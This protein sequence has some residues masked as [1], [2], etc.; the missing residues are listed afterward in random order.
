MEW[1]IINGHKAGKKYTRKFYEFFANKEPE[2]K[3]HRFKIYFFLL[4]RILIFAF[5]FDGVF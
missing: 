5:D 4:S 3:T 1:K 2:R